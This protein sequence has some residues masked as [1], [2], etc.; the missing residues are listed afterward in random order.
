[1]SLF[2]LFVTKH[3]CLLLVERAQNVN[4]KIVPAHYFLNL[5]PIAHN[6]WRA[7]TSWIPRTSG[8]L[9]LAK[10]KKIHIHISAKKFGKRKKVI[11]YFGVSTKILTKV[12]HQKKGISTIV[13][14]I[15]FIRSP[16]CYQSTKHFRL[17][18]SAQSCKTASELNL[19][20]FYFW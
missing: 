13:Q 3:W 15:R 4:A 11:M 14:F 20:I 17:R 5:F 6:N 16:L 19:F 18:E 8:L 10:I 1:M 7:I 9:L 12:L 2:F